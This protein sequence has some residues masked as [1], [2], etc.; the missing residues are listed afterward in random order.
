MCAWRIQNHQ[1][2]CHRIVLSPTLHQITPPLHPLSSPPAIS[3]GPWPPSPAASTAAPAA[4]SCST[5]AAWPLSA[6]KCSGVLPQRRLRDVKG[7]RAP[8]RGSP[9]HTPTCSRTNRNLRSEVR[10]FHLVQNCIPS[11][12]TGSHYRCWCLS[13]SP[14]LRTDG[15]YNRKSEKG[16]TDFLPQTKHLNISQTCSSGLSHQQYSSRM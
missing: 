1:T 8:P 11:W 16:K 14:R 3:W 2:T 9:P 4:R 6:A 15:T 5:T 10:G 7:W 13:R 12:L